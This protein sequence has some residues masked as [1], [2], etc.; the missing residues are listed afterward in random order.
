MRPMFN[1]CRKYILGG[2]FYAYLA[3]AV[4]VGLLALAS[5]FLTGVVVNRLATGANADIVSVFICCLVLVAVQAVRAA[6]VYCSEMLYVNLQSHAG[7]GLNADT[8]EHVKR[9]PQLFFKDFDAS[10]LNQQI[11]HDANDLAIFV[12]NSVVGVSSNIVTLLVAFLILA[13]LNIRLSVV[14]LVLAAASAAFYAGSR[15]RLFKRS[16]D[17]QERSARFFS[18]L[19]DQL[20]KVEFIRKH[21]LFEKFRAILLDAFNELYPS[22]KASQKASS[23]FSL[24]NT[25]V[26][27][28][29]QGYLLVVGA[30]EVMDGRLLPGFLV[31]AVGYYS[32]LNT[33][34]QYL[35]GWGRDYQTNRV[36]YER[37][38]RIWDVPEEAN[39]DLV[40][41]SIEE[42][43][44]KNVRLR[45][46][47]SERIA[48][49]A[50]DM[51]F[52]KGRLYGISGPNGSG[53]SSLLSVLLG[54]YPDDMDGSVRY[55]GVSQRDLDRYA[56]RQYRIGVTEQEPPVVN[57]TIFDNLTL[58]SGDSAVDGLD[59][60]IDELGLDEAI[61]S[62]EDGM[63]TILGGGKEGVS[64]GEKQKIA[65]VRQLLKSPD[66]MLFDEPTSALDAR[67]R[68]ALIKLLNAAKEDHI[69][70]VVTHDKEMLTACDEIIQMGANPLD[71]GAEERGC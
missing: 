49:N 2:L 34:V 10:Y 56:L 52:V 16:F 42:I 32:S 55:N 53:K 17:V 63:R 23:R 36:C 39:G 59:R 28:I 1:L 24:G 69:V 26:A 9:L 46:P 44:L 54:L 19:Q 58:L 41:N 45:Y 3:A 51:T 11:N 60:M 7:F 12:I 57:G 31:T 18:S 38:K 50:G 6:L 67:S 68:V 5:P 4:L 8:L 47:G 30:L 37:L 71:C 61:A 48:L 22:V 70:I 15:E 27:S 66:V 13:G 14:C 21:I 20:D 43:H 62:A 40:L 65:I 33:A 25:L 64:G 35:L 29:A